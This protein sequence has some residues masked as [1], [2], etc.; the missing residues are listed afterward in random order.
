MKTKILT[1]V[2][3]ALLVFFHGNQGG[4]LKIDQGLRN[5]ANLNQF[6]VAV[7]QAT[8][9]AFSFSPEQEKKLRGNGFVVTPG[10]FEQF[11]HIYQSNH[12]GTEPSIPNFI[13][14]DCVLQL[15]HLFYDFTLRFIELEALLPALN[16]LTSI[17]VAGA[18]FQ[19]Q[20]A[21]DPE[22]RLAALKNL[23]FFGVAARLLGMDDQLPEECA[24]MV[25]AEVAK[26][27]AHQGRE[28]SSIFP[29]E[30][31]YTQYIPRGHYTRTEELKRFFL[32]MMWYGQNSFA[33]EFAGERIREQLLQAEL[34]TYLL[35]NIQIEQRPAIYLWDKIYSVTELYVGSTDDL[36]PYHLNNLMKK[37]YGETVALSA[38]TDRAKL[39]RLYEEASKLPRPRIVQ[40]QAGTTA[41]LQFRFMGQRFIPDSYIMQR[42][43]H[44]PERVWPKG[45]DVMAVLGSVRAAEF[46]DRMYQEPLQWQGYLPQRE[47]LTIQFSNL[48]EDDWYQ[49]LYYGWL[50][51]LKTL[52]Q[53]KGENYPWF[54]QNTAWLDKQLNTALASWTE[55]RHDAILY[56]KPS[57]AEG[58]D[59]YEESQYLPKGYVEPVP[60]FYQ[61]LLKLLERHKMVLSESG[62]LSPEIEEI[63]NSFADLVS[64]LRAVSLKELDQQPLTK[65]EYERIRDFGGELEGLSLRIVVLDKA[66]FE[67]LFAEGHMKGWFNVTGPDRDIACIADV[68]TSLADCLEEAVG[69]LNLIY[70]I[71]P[72]QGKLYLTRGG[73]FSYYEFT[74]PAAHRLNDEAW[75]EMLKRSRAPNRPVWTASFIAQ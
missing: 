63:L 1:T 9:R 65:Q 14:S 7:E 55:M 51:L 33:F 11:F 30:H 15:Y 19:Y 58:C 18:K 27:T 47:S 72:I 42:L 68:H 25:N 57:Y 69:H 21:T 4:E 37:V 45:L 60:I 29:Y 8:G 62:F 31:D 35:F 32:A 36:N 20:N 3:L 49:N 64:F 10:D 34:I 59:D 66:I 54:M 52:L 5:V 44:W 46:L 16:R 13:T 22:L 53:E 12:F 43:V 73:V 56:A 74:Y 61:R 26:I 75:Q 70:V 2:A 39:D 28:S 23:T 40:Q 6:K 24:D 38:L 71:V 67:E 50:Y 48:I 41:G 17:I